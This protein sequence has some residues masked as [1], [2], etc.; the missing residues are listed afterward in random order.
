MK[1]VIAIAVLVAVLGALFTQTG[2]AAFFASTTQTITQEI[3]APELVRSPDA[4]DVFVR[5]GYDYTWYFSDDT[6]AG[7]IEAAGEYSG[8][9]YMLYMPAGCVVT[10]IPERIN[11][12]WLDSIIDNVLTF[13]LEG[14]AEF[15]EPCILYTAEGGKIYQDY[16]TGDWLGDGEWVEVGSFTSIIDGEA[17]LD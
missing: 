13:A 9:Q 17:H 11:W 4:F 16:W 1:K 2:L 10:G 14:D 8:T 3:V 7:S 5:L 12:L 6:L 15:S